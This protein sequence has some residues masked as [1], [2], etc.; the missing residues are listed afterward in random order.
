MPPTVV[1]TGPG[2][3]NLIGDHTDYNL[4]LALP[5]AIGLGVTVEVVPSG[6]DRVVAPVLAAA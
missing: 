1:R 3:V 4:G 5:V 6:D 2:R